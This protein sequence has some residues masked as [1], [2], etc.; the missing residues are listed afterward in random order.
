MKYRTISR[1][2]QAFSK[3]GSSATACLENEIVWVGTPNPNRDRF[4]TKVLAAL[5]EKGI[6]FRYE[7]HYVTPH[8]WRLAIYSAP[9]NHTQ[10]EITLRRFQSWKTYFLHWK[11]FNW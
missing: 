6:R 11:H 8:G 7:V 1:V 2:P 5:E 3:G 10:I 9:K 4:V